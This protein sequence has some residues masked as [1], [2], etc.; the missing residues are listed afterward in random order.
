MGGWFGVWNLLRIA[1][2]RYDFYIS[3]LCFF[4]VQ[5]TKNDNIEGPFIFWKK[6]CGKILLVCTK[7]FRLV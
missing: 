7:T 1:K 6:N 5:A 2:V 3:V 4:V